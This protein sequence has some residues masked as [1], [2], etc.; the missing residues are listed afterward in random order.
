[1]STDT[2]VYVTYIATTPDK[3]WT[4]LLEG[5]VTRQY[6]FGN[7][8]VAAKGWKKGAPWQH[9]AE[10]GKGAIRCV[11]EILEII[12]QQKLVLS[13]ADPGDAANPAKHS[14]V[15][16][17]LEKMGDMVRLTV[18]HEQLDQAMSQKISKGWPQVCASMKSFLE[19]G[20]A[21]PTMGGS[22]STPTA[23]AHES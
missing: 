23:G 2:F 13:W 20:R 10:G 12:P 17:E 3:V 5:E 22:C 15:A 9:V 21:L 18:T 16:L 14:R 19:T 8:N 6:W 11:G 7:V 1:V 4:A